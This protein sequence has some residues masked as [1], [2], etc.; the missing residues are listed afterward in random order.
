MTSNEIQKLKEILSSDNIE[1]FSEFLDNHYLK[2][3]IIEVLDDSSEASNSPNI[4]AIKL[5]SFH[6][7]KEEIQK[8]NIPPTERN[9]DDD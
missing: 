3:A 7:L 5:Y 2:D 9:L 1:K 4:P 8:G 6:E